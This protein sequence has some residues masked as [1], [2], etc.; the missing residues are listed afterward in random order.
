MSGRSLL[1]LTL[2]LTMAAAPVQAEIRSDYL[3][4]TDPDCT[5]LPRFKNEMRQHRELW[6]QALGRPEVDLQRMSAESIA[7][8]AA[9]EV[10]GL[11]SANPSLE[12]ILQG[13]ST[14]SS[15]RFSA[16][17]AL[18]ALDARS[19]AAALFAAT[20]TSGSEL[21]QL[22]EPALADWDFGPIK[23][24]WRKRLEDKNTVRTRELILALR[25]LGQVKETSALPLLKAMTLDLT[26]ISDLRLESASAAGQLTETGLEEDAERLIREKR[27]SRFVNCH[28]AIRFLTRHSNATAIRL[29]TELAADTE[30]SLA[31]ASLQRLNEID[32]ALVLPLVPV[33]LKNADANVRRQA[34]RAYVSLPTVERIP[35]L[36]GLLDDPH[37]GLRRQICSDLWDLSA[38]DELNAV[39][40]SSA[41]EILN[42]TSWRG[43]QQGALLLGMLEH[44]PAASRLVELLE[45]PRNEV[46]VDAAWG[47]R[48]IADPLTIDPI[49]D[50]IQRQ[51]VARKKIFLEVIDV[52]VAHLFE[53]CGRMGAK[54]AEPLMR[55]YIPKDL[56]M[57]ER[58]RSAAIWALGWIHAGTLE[59][60]LGTLLV[61]RIN[62]QSMMPPESFL[63]KEHCIIA[64]GRMKGVKYAAEFRV[65]V[66]KETPNDRMSLARRWAIRELTGE[67]LP[68]PIAS[69]AG[70]G[71]W[72][73]EPILPLNP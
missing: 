32:P 31:A 42:Q 21:R 15:A 65:P 69:E 30:P 68:P 53:A 8:A 24:I 47:L 37:P 38:K 29:F 3:M 26:Q 57:G 22:V 5:P 12:K 48:K 52:Q 11:N 7:L 51:T 1:C 2:L 17:R 34:A 43:Q 45:S 73:L 58:S 60:S 66:E 20:Q 67:E 44:Q 63:V 28:C 10:P 16:A 18:I 49:I 46:L 56:I 72:F 23:A 55:T 54:Q 36:A 41:L 27:G 50:K 39:V 70:P 71:T 19:S 6:I 59:E 40:R 61:E 14:H 13:E 4:D 64:I 35:A 33:A 62:D 25:G 9:K